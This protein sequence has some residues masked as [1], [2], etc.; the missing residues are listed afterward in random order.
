MTRLEVVASNATGVEFGNS[1]GSAISPDGGTVAFIAFSN[2]RAML[3]VRKVDSLEARV[4]ADT[5]N[6]GRP[7]WSPDSRTIG[8]FANGKLFR[9]DVAGGSPQAL[10]DTGVGRGGT[11][12]KDGVILWA[13]QG[14]GI[15]R[16][17]ASGGQPEPVTLLDL[18]RQEDSH[19]YPDFLPMADGSFTSGGPL[20]RKR[21]ST[22]VVWTIQ[23]WAG[24]TA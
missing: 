6:A 22:S 5:E 12:N 11:W 8:Y 16:V 23:K 2:D 17:P 15:Q 24:M 7:F 3:H 1:A 14:K 13:G 19:Y 18:A 4:L 21:G 10:C 20:R 9:I